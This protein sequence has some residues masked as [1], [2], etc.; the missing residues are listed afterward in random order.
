MVSE[1]IA[2]CSFS[3]CRKKVFMKFDM[4]IGFERTEAG[5]PIHF[6]WVFIIVSA[7]ALSK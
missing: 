5:L 6:L 4:V 3:S 2:L 1:L 7:S